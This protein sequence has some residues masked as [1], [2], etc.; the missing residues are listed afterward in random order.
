LESKGR[1]FRLPYLIQE[2][3]FNKLSLQKRLKAVLII[4]RLGSEIEF[5]CYTCKNRGSFV[6]I[7]LFLCCQ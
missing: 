7:L 2:R 6:I 4:M 1:I 3:S 5:G